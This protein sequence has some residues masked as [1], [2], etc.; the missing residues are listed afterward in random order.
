MSDADLLAF[1]STS[2]VPEIK[3]PWLM[4]HGDNCFLPIA[5]KRHIEAI[6][7]DTKQEVVW[8][9]TPHLAYC[10]QPDVF[11]ATASRVGQ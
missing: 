7:P 1:E 2:A 8:D 11:D 10:D 5:A 6:A 3:A 4:V 9:D